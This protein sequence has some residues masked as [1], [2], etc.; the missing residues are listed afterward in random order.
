MAD[1]TNSWTIALEKNVPKA[2]PARPV[3]SVDIGLVLSRL[4]PRGASAALRKALGKFTRARIGP[5]FDS[6][7]VT[8]R[9]PQR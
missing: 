1:V 2:F 9:I 5:G 7:P 6:R 3:R 4:Y 8:P